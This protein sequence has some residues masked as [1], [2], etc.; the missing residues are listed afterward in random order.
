MIYFTF[1]CIGILSWGKV[2]GVRMGEF[3]TKEFHIR[4][5]M[6]GIHN[7]A[8]LNLHAADIIVVRLFLKFLS[9]FRH[10]SG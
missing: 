10:I 4:C 1:K 6:F 3:I 9:P 5:R 8:Y 7:E 2:A